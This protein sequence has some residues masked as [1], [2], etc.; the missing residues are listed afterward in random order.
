MNGK[1]LLKKAFALEETS[2]T[3]WVPFVGAHGGH[4]VG[5]DAETYLKSADHIVEGV[6]KAVELYNPDGLPV[7]FDLQLEAEAL[8]CSLVWSKDNPP[9]VV[10]HPLAEGK[11][12]DEFHIP[13][14]SDGRIALVMEA[15]R[16]S[17]ENH[18]EVLQQYV[19]AQLINVGIKVIERTSP[20]F[21]TWVDRTANGKHDATIN[22]VFN[23]G[24]PVIGVHRT[25][26][27]SNIRPGA[28]YSNTSNYSNPEMD[29]LLEAAGAEMDMNKR[30]ALYA[31]F[32]KKIVD[33]CPVIY[34]TVLPYHMLYNKRVGNPNESPWGFFGP[35]DDIYIK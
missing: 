18:P 30:K 27:T 8:G 14:A 34:L 3:P 1:S 25:Y 26:I 23:W 4:L 13:E 9:A 21:A 12:L 17:A 5:M 7:M 29:T 35:G 19:K 10:S 20:D 11:S 6:D 31:D 16:R 22:I 15:C 28:P 24:D 2:R 32:Q 33:E